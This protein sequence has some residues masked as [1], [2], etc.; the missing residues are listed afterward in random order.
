MIWQFV[1]IYGSILRI[2]TGTYGQ[3]SSLYASPKTLGQGTEKKK[4]SPTGGGCQK[5]LHLTAAINPTNRVKRR[6]A[7]CQPK[8][9]PE[10]APVFDISYA[11]LR[12]NPPRLILPHRR[13]GDKTRQKSKENAITSSLRPS[14]SSLFIGSSLIRPQSSPPPWRRWWSRTNASPRPGR[15]PRCRLWGPL[16]H[17]NMPGKMASRLDSWNIVAF[18]L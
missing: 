10:E 6:P 17:Q 12:W 2:P 8:K 7:I 18:L 3:L 13:K 1:Y 15:C 16:H 14:P 5:L 11:R 9:H 4:V